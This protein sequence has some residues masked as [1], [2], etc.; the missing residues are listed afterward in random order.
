MRSIKEVINYLYR[1]K[2]PILIL[3]DKHEIKGYV[4]TKDIVVLM[5]LGFETTESIKNEVKLWDISLI[6]KENIETTEAFPTLNLSDNNID[7]ISKRE[8]KYLTTGDPS[9]LSLDFE[10]LLRNLPI[11]VAI[12]DRFSKILW[13]NLQFLK[14][15]NMSEEEI[16]GKDVSLFLPKPDSIHLDNK[17][18][19]ILLSEMIVY[20]VKIKSFLLIY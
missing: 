4:K 17:N 2:S 13:A 5:N 7:L 1:F 19:K 11:P 9:S 16:I 14:L 12:A 3:S 6:H 15:F 10:I 18:F 20:D 8:L